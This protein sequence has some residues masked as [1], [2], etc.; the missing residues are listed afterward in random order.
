M[1]VLK[2]LRLKNNLTQQELA[3]LV[4]CTPKYIG[5]LENEERTPSLNIAIKIS[6][7]FNLPIEDIFLNKK[8]TKC[9]ER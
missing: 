3:N 6:K 7:L 8:C 4:G 5:F 2:N 9:T 1:S